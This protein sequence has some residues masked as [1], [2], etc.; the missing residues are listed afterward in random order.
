VKR[1]ETCRPY[2]KKRTNEEERLELEETKRMLEFR[3]ANKLDIVISDYVRPEDYL[4]R[5]TEQ[6]RTWNQYD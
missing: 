5:I 3:I 6:L 4:T 1:K 2:R